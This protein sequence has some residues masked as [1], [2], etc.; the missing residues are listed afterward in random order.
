MP[1][2]MAGGQQVE[3]RYGGTR[4]SF[5]SPQ[6]PVAA[7]LQRAASCSG[8]PDGTSGSIDLQRRRGARARSRFLLTGIRQRSTTIRPPFLGNFLQGPPRGPRDE[9]RR[10]A[11]SYLSNWMSAYDPMGRIPTNLQ[12]AK[13]GRMGVASVCKFGRRVRAGLRV[14]SIRGEASTRPKRPNGPRPKGVQPKLRL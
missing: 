6:G 14:E 2:A 3:S 10:W 5:I 9:P 13:P 1:V 8:I 7:V 11:V 12:I 4:R